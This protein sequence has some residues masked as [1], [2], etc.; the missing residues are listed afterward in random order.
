MRHDKNRQRTIAVISP[1]GLASQDIIGRCNPLA[2][3]CSITP[4]ILAEPLNYPRFWKGREVTSCN[5]ISAVSSDGCSSDHCYSGSLALLSRQQLWTASV[6]VNMNE[7]NPRSGAWLENES[8]DTR[9]LQNF[10]RGYTSN[11]LS[12]VPRFHCSK[13]R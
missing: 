3:N 8:H 10:T 13:P 7:S 1:D 4:V 6:R 9:K 12:I 5:V 2:S 11:C